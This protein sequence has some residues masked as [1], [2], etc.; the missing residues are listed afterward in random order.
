MEVFHMGNYHYSE[1][2]LNQLRKLAAEGMTAIEI[3]DI[4]NRTAKGIRKTCRRYSIPLLYRSNGT[5]HPRFCGEGSRL[6]KQG[7][8]IDKSGY[9]LI[10]APEH[11]FANT[12]GYVR[13][14]RLVM[15]E[16]LGRYLTPLEVVHHID[17]DKLNNSP[18][19]LERFDKNSEHLRIELS[20]KC[21][22]W[23]PQGILAIQAGVDKIRKQEPLRKNRREYS[24]KWA[25]KKRALRADALQ[26]QRSS[27]QSS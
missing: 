4:L 13:E 20:G 23:T 15:E 22:K 21:P 2:D 9:R 19:N 25:A 5:M 16:I 18:E 26:K 27:S 3:G 10:F 1:D 14:H 12:S 7:Y 6:W 17:G 11:P 8:T 24:R